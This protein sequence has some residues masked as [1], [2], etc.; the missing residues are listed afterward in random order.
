[1]STIQKKARAVAD[2]SEGTILATVDIASPPERV[3]RALSSKEICEWWGAEGLYRTTGW[4]GDV[5]VGG[6]WR[7]SGVGADG[8]EFA[9]EG[10]YLEVDPPRKLAHTWKP[11]W[12]GGKPTTVKYRL[13][14]VDGGT[15]VTVR[16]EGF[17]SAESCAGHSTG[18]E[19]VLDWLVAHSAARAPRRVFLLRLIAPRPTFA[20]DM[21]EDERRVMGEHGAYWRKLLA[22]GVAIA[23]GPV[24]DPK[25]PWGLGLIEVDEP[26]AVKGLTA[27]DPAIRSGLGFD[28]EVLPLLQSV[29][30]AP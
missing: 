30:R 14:A 6:R 20:F 4:T 11:D 19:R 28:Y 10:E 18:W 16:H 5:R 1:M 17:D 12:D 9:V 8:H 22:E 27:G 3:F 24:N 23:F 2:V 7:A 29:V 21:K 25:G 15:R 13:E 26:E